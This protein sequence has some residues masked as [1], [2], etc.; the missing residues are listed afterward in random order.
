MGL[1][2]RRFGFYGNA[3][4]KNG[5]VRAIQPAKIT[6]RAPFGMDELGRMVAVGVERL[7]KGEDFR[8][9]KLD[10]KAAALAAI[11]FDVYDAAKLPS[12]GGYDRSVGHAHLKGR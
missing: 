1:G 12:L 11:P 9:A 6:S 3:H 8:R 7:G 4:A 10:A 2:L 5:E